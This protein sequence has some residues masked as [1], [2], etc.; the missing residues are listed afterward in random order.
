MYTDI[1]TQIDNYQ[2]PIVKKIIIFK[3]GIV[4]KISHRKLS[5]P[6]YHDGK[7]DF[8]FMNEMGCSRV[9]NRRGSIIWSH[10]KE[11]VSFVENA[12]EGRTKI[13]ACQAANLII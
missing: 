7:L 2:V 4:A 5:R 8:I 9:M 6:W 1:F 10:F 11:M 12:I 3:K 13:R